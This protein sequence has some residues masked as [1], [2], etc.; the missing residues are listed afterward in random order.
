MAVLLVAGIGLLLV[1]A[2]G[3]GEVRDAI[4]KADSTWFVVCLGAQLVALSA[5]A[6]VFRGAFSWNGTPDPGFR[7][8]AYV[9]LASIG[10]TRVFAA[11]GVGAIAVTYWCFRRARHSADEALVR[12]LGLQRALLRRLRGRSV[13]RRARDDHGLV[14]RRP[15]GIRVAVARRRPGDRRGCGRRDGTG[16]RRAVDAAGRVTSRGAPSHTPSAAVAWVRSALVDPA[17]RR[18]LGATV[19]YWIGNLACL[20]ASLRSVG[21]TVPFPELVLA[22]AAGHAAMILPLP[23]GGVGGVDAALTY[24]LTTV[25]VPLALALVAVGV[26]RLFSFWLPTVPALAALARA[27]ARRT[28]PGGT[29]RLSKCGSWLSRAWQLSAWQRPRMLPTRSGR[30]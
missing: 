30:P 24:A 5:Y 23:L 16:A 8:S 15:A 20:W 10:A 13:D 22:F 26:Y 1:R 14:G 11:G 29:L 4:E 6:A 9:M 19:L 25:G 28:A 18:L 12:V 17:G 27:A 7:L 3:F 2:A 21:E